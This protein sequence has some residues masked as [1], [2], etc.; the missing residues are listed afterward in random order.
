LLLLSLVWFLC[1]LVAKVVLVWLLRSLMAAEGGAGMVALVWLLKVAL[2][3]LLRA[4]VAAEGRWR[5]CG[6]C[7]L[8][9]LLKVCG[10]G[11][12]AVRSGGC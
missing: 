4:L 6:C 10:A 7:A 12:V 2:M 3:W 9:W 11:V 5:W 1:A 8:W